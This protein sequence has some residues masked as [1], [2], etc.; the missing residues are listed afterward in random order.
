MTI[1][2]KTEKKFQLILACVG[3]FFEH[4]DTALFGFL[5][6]FLAPLLF[7]NHKPL[8]ALLL[9]YAM[10]PLGMVARPL[11]SIFFGYL[12]DHWG[13]RRVLFFTLTGTGFATCCLAF[14]PLYSQVGII[15]PLLFCM[16]RV[17]QNFFAAGE[18]VGGALFIFE[19]T[20]EK[21]H[22]ILSGLYNASTLGGILMASAGVS[23]ICYLDLVD[24][25]WRWI[26]LVGCSTTICGF[27]L[28]EKRGEVQ[29]PKTFLKTGIL[30]WQYRKILAVIAVAAGFSYACYSIA[31]IL[32]NGL[33]PLISPHTNAQ[34]ANLNTML[35]MID[36]FALPFFGWISS[37][38][39]REKVMFVSAFAIAC[40][41][42]PLFALLEN[43]SLGLTILIRLCFVC[44]GV[45][46]SAPF[47]AWANTLVPASHR[48]LIIS[49]GY[50]LGSQ[51]L[52]A[53]TSAISLWFYEQT[54][55]VAY[56]SLYWVTLA[57]TTA[58]IMKY[59]PQAESIPKKLNAA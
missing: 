7:P 21:H 3:N 42:L 49:L 4:Y 19:N 29:R 52:G 47:Q 15:A 2:Q 9:T 50:A 55:V 43:A 11:G 16:G 23:L 46:F 6:P 37:R 38:L 5:S 20:E 58:C 28:R 1:F 31:L 56:A 39:T 36:F 33:I 45:A 12:G 22:D 54:Q 14:C 30:L 51:L 57:L 32:L 34:M 24:V 26:Y 48:Y 40:L 10:I 17:L 41:G 18:S 53:P 35:L 25:G 27:L 8:I 13:R 59:Q 44:G